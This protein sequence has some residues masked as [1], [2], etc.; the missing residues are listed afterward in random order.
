MLTQVIKED[1]NIKGFPKKI[2]EQ[3]GSAEEINHNVVV[4]SAFAGKDEE[5]WDVNLKLGQKLITDLQINF[6]NHEGS[7]RKMTYII[8]KVPSFGDDDELFQ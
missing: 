1:K 5:K 8:N 6:P 3:I 2:L 7:Q 4:F